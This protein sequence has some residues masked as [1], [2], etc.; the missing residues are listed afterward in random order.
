MAAS[1]VTHLCGG[2]IVPVHAVPP[3]AIHQQ[4]CGPPRH[5]KHSH[6]RQ[7]QPERLGQWVVHHPP[8]HWP[9]HQ[10]Q[11]S[12]THHFF[13]CHLYFYLSI[14]SVFHGRVAAALWA[15]LLLLQWLT[16][17]TFTHYNSHS[18]T[19]GHMNLTSLYTISDVKYRLLPIGSE[20]VPFIF[21]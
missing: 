17:T 19:H 2:I 14:Y 16:H 5:A 11:H 7:H 18:D 12:I 1:A 13:P 10:S 8:H 4:L 15:T 9:L 3:P 20:N 21:S 6:V